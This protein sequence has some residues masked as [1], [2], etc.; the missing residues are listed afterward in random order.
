MPPSVQAEDH[1]E[2]VHTSCP[3]NPVAVDANGGWNIE[4]S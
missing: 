2:L 1:V 3:F 4:A